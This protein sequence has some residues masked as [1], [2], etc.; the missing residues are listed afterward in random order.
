[1]TIKE[2]AAEKPVIVNS[3]SDGKNRFIL[4]IGNIGGSSFLVYGDCLTDAIDYLVD[5]KGDTFPGFF[6]ND[7][8]IEKAYWDESHDDHAYAQDNYFPAGDAGE[9]FTSE[10]VVLLEQRKGRKY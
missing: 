9:L 4:I 8:E 10:I 5:I 1:M 3:R 2:I 6:N 7:P